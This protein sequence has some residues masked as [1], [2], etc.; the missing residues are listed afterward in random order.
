MLCF[1]LHVARSQIRK[2]EAGIGYLRQR[3]KCG[4]T[5][6]NR[7]AIME[8]VWLR[9]LPSIDHVPTAFHQDVSDVRARPI[10]SRN[11]SALAQSFRKKRAV[12]TSFSEPYMAVRSR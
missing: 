8:R 7:P 4:K 3:R 12:P 2:Y 11:L 6:S 1:V 5:R 10:S 9:W